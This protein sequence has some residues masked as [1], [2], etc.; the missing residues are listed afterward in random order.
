M[1]TGNETIFSIE[2]DEVEEFEEI[3]ETVMEKLTTDFAEFICDRICGKITGMSE[4]D[5]AEVCADCEM[6]LYIIKIDNAY[7]EL[8]LF[9]NTQVAAVM[10]KYSGITLCTE[11]EYRAKDEAGYFWCRCASGIIGHSLGEKDGCSIG[12]RKE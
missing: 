12:K 6:G 3:E 11:C 8:N 9:D 5:A 1:G 7:N 10:K 2:N 4:E